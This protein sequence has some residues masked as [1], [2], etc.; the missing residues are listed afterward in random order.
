MRLRAP[1]SATERLRAL[2]IS[3]KVGMDNEMTRLGLLDPG[4]EEN[5]DEEEDGKE[6]N[7]SEEGGRA[8]AAAAAAAA[9]SRDNARRCAPQS[10]ASLSASP[11]RGLEFA[12]GF[13]G[14]RT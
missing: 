2:A 11:W 6:S 5:D 8:A 9:L 1:C 10:P 12:R 3:V 7:V 14:R 13:G 4:S